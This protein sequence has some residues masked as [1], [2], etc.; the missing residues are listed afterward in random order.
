M[1]KTATAFLAYAAALES[2]GNDP[3]QMASFCTA[4]GDTLD[5]LFAA[6]LAAATEESE[7]PRKQSS[8]RVSSMAAKYLSADADRAAELKHVTEVQA[9]E[10]RRMDD[11]VRASE[12]EASRLR[13]AQRGVVATARHIAY[14]YPDDTSDHTLVRVEMRFVRAVA[15]LAKPAERTNPQETTAM[16]DA[17]IKRMVERFL[18]WRLPADFAPDGG[19]TFTP[20]F[21]D[22]TEHPQRHEPT[23]TNLLTYTQ[24]DAMVRHMLAPDGDDQGAIEPSRLSAATRE[25]LAVTLAAPATASLPKL[26]GV[27]VQAMIAEGT[28]GE[29]ELGKVLDTTMQAMYA[30]ATRAR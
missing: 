19:I 10:L 29:R 14:L 2:C 6:T 20:T 1:G 9:S 7:A 18:A 8:T 28:P 5:S 11:E 27:I 22:H 26:L 15:A 23:G 12:A 13:E 17:Q 25:A 30:A 4:Q 16:T 24:A 3:T 21:N